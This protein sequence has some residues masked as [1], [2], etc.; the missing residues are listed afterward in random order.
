MTGL[1]DHFKTDASLDPAVAKAITAWLV[2]NARQ[3]KPGRTESVPPP[4][5]ITETRWFSGEHDE[6]SPARFRSAAV[7]SPANCGACHTTAD[8]GD[9][10]ED[11]IRMPPK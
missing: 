11:N 2:A 9:F 3:P 4:L 10:S 8:R 1:D 7:G 5:R 6:I